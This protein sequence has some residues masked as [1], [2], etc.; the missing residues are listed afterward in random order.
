MLL[1][2]EERIVISVQKIVESYSKFK[3]FFWVYSFCK[4][5]LTCIILALLSKTQYFLLFVIVYFSI[6]Y[7]FNTRNF[8]QHFRIYA[9]LLKLYA[10][11]KTKNKE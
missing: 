11:V 6:A 9:I 3:I 2:N 8:F 7:I 10:E 4:M 5:V 1:P